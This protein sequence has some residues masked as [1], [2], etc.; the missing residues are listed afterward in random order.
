VSS[1]YGYGTYYNCDGAWYQPQYVGTQITYVV[2]DAPEGAA[3][4]APPPE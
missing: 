4:T 3:A 2:V 1:V